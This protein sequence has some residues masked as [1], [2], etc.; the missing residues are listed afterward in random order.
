[1]SNGTG[2]PSG[3]PQARRTQVKVSADP[4]VADAFRK[5]CAASGI[6]MA[7]E[8]SRFMADYSS[9]LVKR[10]AAPDY[11]TRRR[12]RAAIVAIIKQ[13]E[14]MKAFEERVCKNMPENLQGSAA[15]DA[16]EEA[17]SSLEDAIEALSSF[18]MV[19]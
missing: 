1:M 12:R 18:W 5:A 14:L 10:R 6:S 2:L 17:A 3:P 19:P 8:L 16:A 7:A 15:Y 4:Q 9:G 13:L 11:T